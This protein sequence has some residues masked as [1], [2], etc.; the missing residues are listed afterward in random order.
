MPLDYDHILNT[1]LDAADKA[2]RYLR[3]TFHQR[4]EIK[5]K[6]EIDLV[7]ERD[8][9]SQDIIYSII[10]NKFDNHSF[11]G[12]EDLVEKR[13]TDLLWLIDP[14]DGTTNYAH[15]IPF[16]A[17][18]IAFL[19]QG[20]PK[21]GVVYNPLLNELF[22]AVKDQGAFLNKKRI[23][24]SGQQ[25][26]TNSLLSTGFPYDLR[27]SKINNLD[28]FNN[29]IYKVRGIRRCGAAAID[30]AYVAAGRFDGFWELK[31]HPW[32][33]AAALLLVQEAGGT[34]TDFSGNPFDPFMK[35][36]LASNGHIHQQMLDILNLQTK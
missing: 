33:T 11:L 15:S 12:E 1:A 20:T 25:K 2:G 7:T 31:L 14:I 29:F 24:V 23:Q 10:K 9:K 26:L 34:I 16:F 17:V 27:K 3:E 22:F 13:D 5:F 6:G 8:K 21:V 32:D 19:E 30:L 35:E 18:S 4:P 28:N 36:C